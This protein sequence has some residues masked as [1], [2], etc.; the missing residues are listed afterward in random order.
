MAIFILE[1]SHR[2]FSYLPPAVHRHNNRAQADSNDDKI[3]V[4]LRAVIMKRMPRTVQSGL[5]HDSSAFSPISVCDMPH[6]TVNTSS[7]YSL[8]SQLHFSTLD[9]L[10][11][12]C[13]SETAPKALPFA[14]RQI[15]NV[16]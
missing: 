4:Y 15:S 3:L 8:H 7:S 2:Q 1:M 6:I 13:F 5:P 12:N 10:R 16:M 14:N 9:L 11:K